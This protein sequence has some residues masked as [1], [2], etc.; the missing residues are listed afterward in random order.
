MAGSKVEHLEGDVKYQESHSSVSCAMPSMLVILIR[1]KETALGNLLWALR[2]CEKKV[3][4]G[5]NLC[6]LM[7]SSSF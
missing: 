5:C 3:E 4:F 2:A 6:L 1:I 7:G